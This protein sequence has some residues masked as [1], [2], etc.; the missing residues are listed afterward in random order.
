MAFAQRGLEVGSAVER[1]RL[2]FAFL[3][4]ALPPVFFSTGGWELVCCCWLGSPFSVAFLCFWTPI[5][6]DSL[7]ERPK[8][9][10]PRPRLP[11][12]N[13]S[14]RSFCCNAVATVVSH[15]VEN[16]A[17]LGCQR[18]RSQTRG[19]CASARTWCTLLPLPRSALPALLPRLAACLLI[20]M[21]LAL[22]K[23]SHGASLDVGQP[24][25]VLLWYGLNSLHSHNRHSVTLIL[26]TSV[27]SLSSICSVPGRAS[28][29]PP[30][31][32]NPPCSPVVSCGG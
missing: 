29:A 32:G 21:T 25:C 26:H 11:P 28:L 20:G 14:A 30:S 15:D 16:A 1:M 22:Q 12:W 8:A 24:R 10:S 4:H 5:A 23:G 18:I 2:R 13:L 3:C 9:L 6:E 31:N 27:C 7:K 19:G 17:S